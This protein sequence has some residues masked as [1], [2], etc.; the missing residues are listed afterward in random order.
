[1]ELVFNKSIYQ[2]ISKWGLVVLLLF[3]VFESRGQTSGDTDTNSSQHLKSYK[4]FLQADM[5]VSQIVK[6]A[7]MFT[8]FSACWLFSKHYYLGIQYQKL[9][10]EEAINNF[11]PNTSKDDIVLE[12]QS[13]G[14]KAGYILFS[15]KRISF[16]PEA[17]INWAMCKYQYP[18][19]AI[20]R[21][22]FL[23]IEPAAN[24]LFNLHKNLAVGLGVSY[25]INAGLHLN[26]LSSNDLNGIAGRVF[27]RF[28]KLK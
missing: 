21:N 8:S 10:S 3:F 15:K 22:N 27:V 25:R 7:G 18:V 9:T 28:G 13:A 2:Q 20:Y 23:V 4:Y 11:V 1:M 19:G 24:I 26:G 5:Q 12:H 14:I 17:T 6:N 16:N